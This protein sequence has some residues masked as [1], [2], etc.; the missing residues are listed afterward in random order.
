MELKH[1]EYFVA[2]AE[3]RSFTRA[4]ARLHVVQSGVSAVIKQL[5]REL[6]AELLER[7]SKRVALTDAGE[8]LLPRARGALDAAQA[9]RDAVGEVRGGLRGTLRIGTLNSVAEID[10]PA[11]LGSFHRSHPEVVLRLTVSPYGSLGLV[12]RLIDGS[13]DLAI[14]SLPGRPPAGIRVRQLLRRRLELV[15]PAGHRL[16]G[17]QEVRI[18]DLADELFV[19]FPAGYGNRIVLD[20]AFAAAG[21]DRRVGVEVIDITSAASYVREGL[22]IS[23]LPRFAVRDETG[24]I[25][26]EVSDVELEWPLGVA[27]SAL[28]APSAAARALVALI[29]ETAA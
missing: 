13:L 12:E 5:E 11:V 18:A 7:S 27:V 4:A 20:R 8:A 9:A 3:E 16:A 17:D 28:R 2:V 14:A 26:K 24:L 6:G 19:D 15:L 23:I 25:L 22:G 10:V 21:F 1:F 29:S